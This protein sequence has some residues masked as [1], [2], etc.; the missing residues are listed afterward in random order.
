MP[1]LNVIGKHL[2]SAVGHRPVGLRWK[3]VAVG[4]DAR[5][6]VLGV[7][8]GKRFAVHIHDLIH[9]VDVV[10]GHANHALDEVL[11]DVHGIA[12]HNHVAAFR[13]GVGQ[14]ML[15]DRISRRVRQLVY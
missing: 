3:I 12:E 13:L 11:A 6:D 4:F 9:D 8:L 10:S 2:L 14:Q 7:G 5:I 15:T 1:V